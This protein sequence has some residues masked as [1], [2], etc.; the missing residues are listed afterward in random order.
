VLERLLERLE[1]RPWFGAAILVGSLATEGDDELSDID[2]L[3]VVSDFRRAWAERAALEGPD[4][5]VSWDAEV[6][7]RVAAHK[8][9][10]RD[11]VLVECLL[12]EPGAFRLAEPFRLLA[13]SASL[14]ERVPRR[15]ALT[16]DQVRG[17]GAAVDPIE[18]AYDE[19][20][21]IVRA[22]RDQRR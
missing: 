10:T 21:D 4:A 17:S 11:L 8:W 6:Q 13:G 16:R 9:L 14:L 1:P 20:K 22:R 3:V 18:R 7:E 15:P 5:L 2:L 19:L 12:G